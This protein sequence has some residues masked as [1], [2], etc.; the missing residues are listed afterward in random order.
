MINRRAR[1]DS[2]SVDGIDGFVKHYRFHQGYARVRYNRS[3]CSRFKGHIFATLEEFNADYYLLSNWLVRIGML[4]NFGL[5]NEHGEDL[6]PE[7]IQ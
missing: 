1:N 4:L 2:R 7:D 5:D 6:Q 3:A